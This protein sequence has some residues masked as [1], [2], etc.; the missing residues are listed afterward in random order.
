MGRKVIYEIGPDRI[1]FGPYAFTKGQIRDDLPD[2]VVD[3]LVRKGRVREIFDSP[4]E[5]IIEKNKA[6]KGGIGN[7]S[8]AR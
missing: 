3:Q 1:S 8:T 7:V 2:E 4:P 6:K 5:V